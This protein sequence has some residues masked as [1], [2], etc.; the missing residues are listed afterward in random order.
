MKLDYII[1]TGIFGLLSLLIGRWLERNKTK[2]DTNKTSADTLKSLADVYNIKVGAEIMIA[3][4]WEKIVG[5]LH[6]DLE[7]ERKECDIKIGKMQG[8]IDE[9]KSEVDQLKQINKERN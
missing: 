3:Q 1:A 9:L 5:E 4:Q 8:K 2:A 6:K 7:Q